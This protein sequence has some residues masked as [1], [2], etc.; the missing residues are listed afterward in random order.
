MLVVMERI[1]TEVTAL[2]GQYQKKGFEDAVMKKIAQQAKDILTG[3]AATR[4]IMNEIESVRDMVDQLEIPDIDSGKA[5]KTL[6]I[7]D[8]TLLAELDKILKGNF[9]DVEKKLDGLGQ[10]MTP[11]GKGRAMLTQLQKAHVV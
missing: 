7:T 8:K 1:E 11:K 5:G 3:V 4:K 2:V 10:K 6:G 9:A